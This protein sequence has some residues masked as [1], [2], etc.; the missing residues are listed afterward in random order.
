MEYKKLFV[1]KEISVDAIVTIHYF[2]YMK[3]FIFEGECH[4]FWELVYVDK[5]EI[6]V[7]NG[8][9]WQ[10]LKKG[11]VIFHKP[12]EFHGLKANGVTAPNLIV[13]S[14]YSNSPEMAFFNE[15]KLF[16]NS[17]EIGLLAS[18]VHEARMSFASGLEDPSADEMIP[19]DPQ[20]AYIQLIA[21]Y[22]EHFLID[23]YRTNSASVSDEV[24]DIQIPFR[25]EGS[26]SLIIDNLM[27]YF[28]KNLSHPLSID[29]ICRDN[30]ISYSKLK[31]LFKTYFDC[32]VI[33]YYNKL[34]IDYAKQLIRSSTKT[35]SEISD[36]LEF[37]SIH[38]FSR[39]FKKMT[40]MSPTEYAHSALAKNE[41]SYSITHHPG[42]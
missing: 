34:R 9:Y 30:L 6:D 1:K 39:F 37:N 33:E 31:Q 11:E 20:F 8:N 3:D 29:M 7:F 42:V 41:I 21:L 14:F 36:F 15:K 12:M 40:G 32:G 25:N 38:Y 16:C 19:G 2:E 27:T 13:I 22:L 24:A 4:D 28:E 5:G 23:M 10:T 26:D 35:V 18:M 17:F